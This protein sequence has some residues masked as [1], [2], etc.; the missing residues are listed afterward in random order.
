MPLLSER[1]RRP[2]QDEGSRWFCPWRWARGWS[3]W[4]SPGPL[5]YTTVLCPMPTHLLP[6]GRPACLCLS[7]DFWSPPRCLWLSPPPPSS[8]GAPKGK[9]CSLP[10][11]DICVYRGTPSLFLIHTSHVFERYRCQTNC[12]YYIMINSLPPFLINQRHP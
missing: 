5:S 9:N 2:T 4:L 6:P 11:S 3:T 10:Q 1:G 12:I 7:M 8:T